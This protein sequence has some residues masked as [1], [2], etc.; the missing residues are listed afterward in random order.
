MHQRLYEITKDR[1]K[2]VVWIMSD[3][4]QS[5]PA[6]VERCLNTCMADYE[7]IGIILCY[8]KGNHDYDYSNK[9]THKAPV[10]PLYETVR[11]HKD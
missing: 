9:H 4:Q 1:A 6:A 10:L 7:R 5:D 11:K 2:H 8:A 3:L